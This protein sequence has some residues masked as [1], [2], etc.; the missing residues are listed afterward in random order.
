[1]EHHVLSKRSRNK[2]R[3]VKPEIVAVVYLALKLSKID[4]AVIDGVRT[5]TR[6]RINF[7]KGVS[8]TMKSKHLIQTDGWGHAVDLMPCGFK[9]FN[10]ITS[11]AWDQVNAAMKEACEMLNFK[12][13]N[14]FDLW[15]WD[16]PH[17]QI[18]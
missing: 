4:F 11:N 12:M 9:S 2:L 16:K 17:W 3:G 7:E 10:D 6:Q 15:G 1:M 13:D 18:T 14:G 5:L 8:K